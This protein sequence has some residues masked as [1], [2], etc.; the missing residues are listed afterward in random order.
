MI[1]QARHNGDGPAADFPRFPRLHAPDGHTVSVRDIVQVIQE[2]DND[3]R[4]VLGLGLPELV[5]VI[6]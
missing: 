6:I 5:I 2:V 1:F 3:Y 4:Y